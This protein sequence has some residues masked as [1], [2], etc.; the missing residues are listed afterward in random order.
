MS[1]SAKPTIRETGQQTIKWSNIW[2][3]KTNNL[4]YNWK[5]RLFHESHSLSPFLGVGWAW[6]LLY[7]AEGNNTLQ[8][9]KFR[10]FNKKSGMQN[11]WIW[12]LLLLNAYGGFAVVV[13]FNSLTPLHA[14]PSP[15]LFFMCSLETAK[16][17]AQSSVAPPA[18]LN[19]SFAQQSSP[20]SSPVTALAA[21]GTL[22]HAPVLGTPYTLPLSSLLGVKPVPLLALTAPPAPVP[23]HGTLASF[24]TKISSANGI[25]KPERQKFAPYW[26]QL[27]PSWRPIMSPSSSK[28]SRDEKVSLCVQQ[29]CF[30]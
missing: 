27:A 9:M 24:T 20:T 30:I 12:F 22:P 28:I 26:W 5:I 8:S 17:T 29:S 10:K 7:L 25:K 19:L 23:A 15:S 14:F 4:L 6:S 16:S 1:C 13:A 18:D 3:K 21:I 2:K 11:T